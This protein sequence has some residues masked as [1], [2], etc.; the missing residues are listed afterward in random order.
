MISHKYKCI[1]VE[2]PKTGT[3]SIRSLIGSPPVPHLDIWQIAFNMQ[4]YWT[5]YGGAANR[6]MSSLYLLLPPKKRIEI[7]KKTFDAYFKFGFV[8]NPWDR[9]VSL[10][11][12]NEGLEMKEKMTFE[13]FVDWIKY[14]SSTCV[15]PGPHTNQ[16]DWFVDPHGNVIVDFIGKFEN[17]RSDWKIVADRLGLPGELPHKRKNRDR[18]HY[19]EYYSEKTKQI[20]ANKFKVDIEY[21]QYT[22]ID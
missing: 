4:H 10:Y 16:L 17:M 13:E 9:V 2:V 6:L 1:F 18:K 20:I 11:L 19:A 5:S 21:F 22:F 7:G 15:I 3:T 12:R 8:R 14:S